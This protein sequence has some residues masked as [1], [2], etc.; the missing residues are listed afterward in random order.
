MSMADP[1]ICSQA[2]V[3]FES[4]AIK[5]MAKT[6]EKQCGRRFLLIMVIGERGLG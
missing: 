1:G 6:K 2:K 4:K 3:V 5:M